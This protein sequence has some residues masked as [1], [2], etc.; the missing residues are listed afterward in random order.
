MI[1]GSGNDTI[2]GDANDNVLTGGAGNDTMV[3]GGGND[4]FIGGTGANSMTGGTGNDTYYVDNVGDVVVELAN[5]GTDTIITTLNTFSLATRWA[6]W[7]T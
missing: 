1:G 4:T 6:T 7:R 2:T 3:G 5:Q